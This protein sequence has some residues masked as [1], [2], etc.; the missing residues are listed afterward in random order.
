MK[1]KII[2]PCFFILGIVNS[3]TVQK[4]QNIYGNAI[5]DIDKYLTLV[6]NDMLSEVVN[7]LKI[8]SESQY[9]PEPPPHTEVARYA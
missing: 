2:C 6:G 3:K 5:S 7:E 9:L 4:T 1:M 8:P